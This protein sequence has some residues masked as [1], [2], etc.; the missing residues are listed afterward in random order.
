M[1][2]IGTVAVAIAAV[3]I[4]F[5]TDWR[6]G[7]RITAE[8]TR[9][10]KEIT[11][12]RALVDQRLADQRAHSDK[13]LADER[14]AAD[15]WLRE[16]LAHSVAQLQEETSAR[17]GP[18]AARRGLPGSGHGRPDGSRMVDSVGRADSLGTVSV[19]TARRRTAPFSGR[20][21]QYTMALRSMVPS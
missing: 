4:A 7:A 19:E 20:S 14:A 16:E 12:E 3:G 1:T 6:T 9:H 21:S 11:D 13:Q 8:R 10:D 5:W 15:A 17:P 2:A 18:E